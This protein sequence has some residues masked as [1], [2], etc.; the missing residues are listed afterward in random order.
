MENT[1]VLIRSSREAATIL[2]ISN[3]RLNRFRCEGDGPAYVKLGPGV[4]ARVGYRPIDLQKWLDSCVRTS[5]SDA[6]TGK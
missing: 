5:T 3:S 4:H 1:E 6:G 2:G